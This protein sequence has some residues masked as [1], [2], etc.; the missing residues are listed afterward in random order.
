[1]HFAFLQFCRWQHHV[2]AGMMAP[3]SGDRGCHRRR[4]TTGLASLRFLLPEPV[5]S[6][7][8]TEPPQKKFEHCVTKV[9]TC[10]FKVLAG[11]IRQIDWS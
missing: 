11:L 3:R 6:F 1:M 5:V 8:A 7:E 10:A 9:L 4:C 2:L